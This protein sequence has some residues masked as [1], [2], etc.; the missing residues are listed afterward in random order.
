MTSNLQDIGHSN[1]QGKQW[2]L[3]GTNDFSG[4]ILQENDRRGKFV[5]RLKGC[6]GWAELYR[7]QL[8]ISGENEDETEK[9]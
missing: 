6:W 8:F 3:R 5:E 4:W 9:G 1:I 7:D 2:H